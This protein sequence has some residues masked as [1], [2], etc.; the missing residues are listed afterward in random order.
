[1]ILLW[2]TVVLEVGMQGLQAHPQKFWFSENLCK[3]PENPGKNGAQRF[4]LQK[5]APKVYIK[6]H[7]N[8]FLEVTKKEVFISLWKKICRQKFHKNFS[9]K[10]GETRAK[11]FSPQKFACSY[12]Y[13]GKAPPPPLP[14]FWKDRGGNALAMPPFSGV[15]VHIILHALSLRVDVGYNVSLLW[16]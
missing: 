13:D 15:P 3:S 4:W 9:G 1:M 7:E 5:M 14:L 16:T 10:F 2:K 11:F 6:T 8:L 12:T